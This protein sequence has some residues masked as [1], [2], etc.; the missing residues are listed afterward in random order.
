MPRKITKEIINERI[1]SRGLF[2]VTDYEAAKI[3]AEF[4]CSLGHFW[5]ATPDS[6][7]RGSGCP[8]CAGNQILSIDVVNSR[9]RHKDIEMI[10]PY[11][12][13]HHATSFRCS[14]DH[15]WRTSPSHVM[16]DT[17]CPTCSNRP[18]LTSEDINSRLRK[19]GITLL[20][21][22]TSMTDIIQV[23]CDN[24]H[25]W[26]D[27]AKNIKGS[28]RT[29]IEDGRRQSL[30]DRKI[31]LQDEVEHTRLLD[32]YDFSCEHGHEWRATLYHILDGAGCPTCSGYGFS[33]TKPAWI[34]ILDF[35]TF[36]KFGITNDIN[37]RLR[38]H[39]RN[40]NY[41]VVLTKLY[42]I[43][44]HARDWERNIKIIFGGRYVTD[45][46]CPDGWTETLSIDKLQSLLET[47]PS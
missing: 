36:I 33:P 40:G 29:C 15:V 9:I 2:M 14:E 18:K 27:V 34:Y 8:I 5:L 17:G 20:S 19:F 38:E 21:N 45:A 3:K 23:R 41:N 44:Q 22:Y 11:L 28:C 13:N 26:T 37:R 16:G 10:G 7:S 12:G 25:I 42:D 39:L 46:V 24:G 47:I 31:I 4:S 35:G 1:S 6:V 32:K 30:S 43:G